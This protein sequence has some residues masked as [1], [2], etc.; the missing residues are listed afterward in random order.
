MTRR[1]LLLDLA[2]RCEAALG[3]DREID[4]AIAKLFHDQ[5]WTA[6]RMGFP[7]HGDTAWVKFTGSLDVAET[8]VPAGHDYSVSRE[9]GMGVA[10][11]Y[12]GTSAET[13]SG[14]V[15]AATPPLALTAAALKAL[16]AQIGESE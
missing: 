7:A 6:W 8:L 1:A 13:I 14:D 12:R 10:C 5:T 15:G 16:A 4:E 3:V 9:G 11:I 2:A